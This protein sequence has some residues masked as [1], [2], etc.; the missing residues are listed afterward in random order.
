MNRFALTIALASGLTLSAC[1]TEPQEADTGSSGDIVPAAA[2]ATD[3]SGDEIVS[4][5]PSDE[6]TPYAG[7]TG[8]RDSS[9]ASGSNNEGAG[10]GATAS[11]PDAGMSSSGTMQSGGSTAGQRPPKGSKVQKADPS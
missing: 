4:E 6:A 1:N 5:G 2:T 9:S 10:G 7:T 11:G 8:G 3:S